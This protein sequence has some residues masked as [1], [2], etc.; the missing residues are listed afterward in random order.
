MARVSFTPHLRRFFDLPAS[1]EVDAPTLAMLVRRLDERW[2]GLGF[3]VT[4]ERGCLRQHVAVWI[5]G[6]PVDDRDTLADPLR[7]ASE[8]HILQALSGG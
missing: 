2:P 4:D 6:T 1:A 7:P 3:Y 8:V 5:D